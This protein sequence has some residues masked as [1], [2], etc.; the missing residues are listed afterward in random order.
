MRSPSVI[1]FIL[2]NSIS[3][4]S[5]KETL[6]LPCLNHSFPFRVTNFKAAT[7]CAPLN[8]AG[9]QSHFLSFSKGLGLPSIT[10]LRARAKKGGGNDAQFV[11]SGV[12]FLRGVQLRQSKFQ[13]TPSFKSLKS[14][15]E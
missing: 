2:R 1:N 4:K 3:L 11:L 12:K 15:K 10:L 14:L 6:T 9:K 8:E 13:L 5:G 7:G